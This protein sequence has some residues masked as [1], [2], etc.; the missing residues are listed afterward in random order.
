M[1]DI[2][3]GGV[4]AQIIG[5][6]ELLNSRER[7][8]IKGLLINR[9]RGDQTLF[10]EGKIWLEAKTGI[11]VIGIL[12][13]IKE[14]FPPEDSLDLLNRNTKKLFSEIEIAVIKLPSL[15]NFSDLDPLEAEPTV[16]LRWVGPND[17]LGKPDAVI[18]P[19]SKQTIKD[20]NHLVS[21]GLGQQIKD[22]SKQGGE[23]LGICG[24]MQM[25]GISL[26]DPSG[27][28]SK[29]SSEISKKVAGLDLLPICTEFK[30][31]KVVKR[32]K[33]SSSWPVKA[34]LD[35]FELH[36][37]FSSV[38][39]TC[40]K[41]LI[42]I[43]EEENLGWTICLENN[44][45]VTGTYLHGIF[46]NGLWRG[47]WLNRLRTKKGLNRLKIKDSNYVETREKQLDFL[48]ERFDEHIDL[49]RFL[50]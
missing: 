14:V 46:E 50:K 34:T 1:A 38:S 9:F 3:R 18:I 7:S 15:S 33:V 43:M 24:G 26:H 29:S 37:G 23:I 41:K 13:W 6:L 45:V 42:A 39:P 31:N 47:E 25:L 36:H 30:K 20:L 2:E 16:Q 49:E 28:E 12:P 35:C 10:K 40:S 22:Y 44:S 4:F 8:L 5:T 19:G 11:P 32:R 27:L 48:S 21:N 17:L